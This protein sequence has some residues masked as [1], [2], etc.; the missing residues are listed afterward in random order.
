MIRRAYVVRAAAWLHALG[1]LATGLLLSTASA[2]QNAR[3]N[4]IFLLTDDQRDNSLGAMGHPFV[5]TPHLDA[6]LRDSVRFRNAY[7]PT[8]VCSPSRVSYFTGLT[9][10][11]HGQPLETVAT[12]RRVLRWRMVLGAL[13]ALM[14]GAS[15]FMLP[16]GAQH[17]EAAFLFLII[18]T[19]VTDPSAR[20]K[21]NP[22]TPA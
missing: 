4:I 8:P 2:A 17:A 21:R 20:L 9:E 12:A 16:P 11:V 18:S 13:V 14:C 7:A 5:K 6:L 10:R 22:R 3:P 19:V 1:I 15:V